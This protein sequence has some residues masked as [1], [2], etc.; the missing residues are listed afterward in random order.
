[1]TAGAPGE[2]L[3]LRAIVRQ[4]FQPNVEQRERPNRPGV[5]GAARAVFLEQAKCGIAIN[6][7]RREA[8]PA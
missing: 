8:G 6:P 1:M 5:I 2:R 7:Y 3:C 4:R